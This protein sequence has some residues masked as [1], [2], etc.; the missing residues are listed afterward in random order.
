MKNIYHQYATSLF[1]CG[2]SVNFEIWIP[3]VKYFSTVF[4]M[5]LFSFQMSFRFFSFFL[6]CFQNTSCMYFG[7]L[8][9]V[10]WI[11]GTFVFV[12]SLKDCTISILYRQAQWV[13]VQTFWI[14]CWAHLTKL[15][16][17]LSFFSVLEF[18]TLFLI[19]PISLLRFPIGSFITTMSSCSSL[20]LFMI[21]ELKYFCNKLNIWHTGRQLFWLHFIFPKCESGDSYFFA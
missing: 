17:C 15:E 21:S 19:V 9:H 14:C 11:P 4:Q 16:F 13:F 7:L 6:S 10:L 18:H 3:W 5:P 20:Y 12:F 8:D 1:L 2:F